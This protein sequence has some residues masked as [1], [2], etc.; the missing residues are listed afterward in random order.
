M[1]EMVA[2]RETVAAVDEV[3]TIGKPRSVEL[4]GI[5]QPVEVVSVLVR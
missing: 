3:F 2:K 5:E 1:A 4:K